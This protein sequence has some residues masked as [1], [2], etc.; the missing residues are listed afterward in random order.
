MSA[1]HAVGSAAQ[2]LGHPGGDAWM[3]A[4]N[5]REPTAAAGTTL[6]ARGSG[7]RPAAA[8]PVFLG[9]VH[10]GQGNDRKSGD[11]PKVNGK[12]TLPAEWKSDSWAA[13]EA[14]KQSSLSN[15]E[16]LAKFRQEYV[17]ASHGH[18][19]TAAQFQRF[20]SSAGGTVVS[21]PG[22]AMSTLVAQSGEGQ[23]LAQT[24]TTRL[25]DAADT[26][27]FRSRTVDVSKLAIKVDLS[28]R[29]SWGMNPT[30]P[31]FGLVGSTDGVSA[32]LLN[33]KYDTGSR[34]LT[35]TMRITV[36]DRFGLSN[37]DNDS[38]GQ[39]SMWL[40]QH[41]RGF[42]SFENKI[43][44]DVPVDITVRPPPVPACNPSVKACPTEF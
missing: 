20:A 28:D 16:L 15:A 14:Q 32:S 30:N 35:G 22:S 9:G 37:S 26:Q 8:A 27:Q 1:V 23:A 6:M 31:M 40:L 43:V 29:L 2:R 24:L 3:A 21:M 34:R 12:P 33:A 18:P 17:L 42:K 7:T 39:I 10:S 5:G 36:V 38:P 19:A 44:Y 25:R 4:L 11:F 13:K 41:Q